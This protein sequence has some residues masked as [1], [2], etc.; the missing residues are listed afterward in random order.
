MQILLSGKGAIYDEIASSIKRYIT[1]GVLKPGEKLPSVREL[2]LSLSVNPN[3]VARSYEILTE[4]GYLV[5]LPK[6][7]CFVAT[8]SHSDPDENV[9]TMLKMA[10]AEGNSPAKI[11][12]L[13]DEIE[14]EMKGDKHD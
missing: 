6:K 3:T 14:G 8:Q 12:S 10:I 11:R 9:K 4:Q 5:S 2:A 1:L 13:L 7:G